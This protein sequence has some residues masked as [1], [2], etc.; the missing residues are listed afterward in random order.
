MRI[1]EYTPPDE[2]ETRIRS[3]EEELARLERS[4]RKRKGL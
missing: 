2:A 4:R 1:C 3:L